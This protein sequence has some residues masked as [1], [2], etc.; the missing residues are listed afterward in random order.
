[1]H[2]IE[3][4][5]SHLAFALQAA[6]VG[7]WEW[8]LRSDSVTWSR[9]LRSICSEVADRFDGS[10][11]SAVALIQD[12]D[13]PRVVRAVRRAIERRAPFEVE[14]RHVLPDGGVQWV[15]SRGQ[16]MCDDA[17]EPARMLGIVMDITERKSA[18]LQLLRRD[19]VLEAV[20]FAA[21]Q[22]LRT[23]NWE[24]SAAEVLARLGRATDASRVYIIQM[25]AAPDGDALASMSFEWVAESIAPQ[26]D[27]PEMHGL[28]LV[29]AG[30]GRWIGLF[31]RGEVLEGNVAALPEGEQAMLRSQDIRSV[32]NVPVM[33]DG[34]WW[35]LL[36][37]DECVS[38]RDWS[39]AERELLQAAARTLGAAIERH[40]AEQELRGSQERF[41]QLV[42]NIHEVFWLSD[43]DKQRMLYVSPSYERIWGQRVDALYESAQAWLAAVH[44]D[45]RDWVRAAV[46]KQATGDYDIEYR[47][48]RPDGLVR[49][50]RDRAFPVT[51]ESGEVVRICG[52][53]EDVSRAKRAAKALRESEA[54]YRRLVTASPYGIYVLNQEGRFTE[55]NPAAEEIMG[56]AAAELLGLPFTELLS[57]DDLGDAL[58]VF[59]KLATG[60]SRQ[61]SF[62]VRIRRPDG[63]S[64]LLTAV[65]TAIVE[66]GAVTGLQ[67]IGR[68]ITE[69][70]ARDEQLRRAERLA[71]VGTMIGGVAHELNNPLAAIRGF[72]QLLMQD[73]RDGDDI[74]ALQTIDREAKRAAQIV[75]DLRLLAR[76]TQDTCERREAVDLN[77]IVQHVLKLRR[78][79]MET[80]NIELREDL[81]ADL[82]RVLGDRAQLEQVVLNLI[83]NAEQALQGHGGVRRIIIRTRASRGGVVLSVYDS[84]PGI[85][86]RHLDRIFDP[87]WTTKEPGEGTGL[88]LSLV[89]R[90]VSEHLGEIHVES[91]PGNGA[92]FMVR[93]PR[94]VGK[95][96]ARAVAHEPEVGASGSRRA[97]RVLVVDDEPPIRLLLRR[98]FSRRGD[99]VDE[100]S[101]GGEA[102]RRIDASAG[103]IPYDLIFSDLRMPG[104]DGQE[105]LQGL[106][107]RGEGWEK[108]LVIMT[109][110]AA[111]LDAERMLEEM[112]VPVMMKPFDLAE[113]PRLLDAVLGDEP[114]R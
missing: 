97:L 49:W 82:P 15:V 6:Q 45:D 39:A 112:G 64:R 76:A 59:Q 111:N 1:L 57:D 12:E 25:D 77:D 78:Y 35:G 20:R 42:D 66:D 80:R 23:G 43:R 63:E 31:S 100:A 109:G 73:E 103:G 69:E 27:S 90:I 8:D 44:P 95:P 105:L 2:A 52:I 29:G 84:G 79:G 21:E 104:L 83:V 19:A 3:N 86:P 51:D 37:F 34:V 46:S 96:E 93:L 67:G 9:G 88:G 81:M 13:R 74:D 60:T 108:R 68:D 102:L 41:L 56:R 110:D 14:Y 91:E 11:D 94:A 28:S 75:S 54:H 114:S 58:D 61:E 106:R 50:I 113:L 85:E 24:D 32:I 71:S 98:F 17:G 4:D 92:A 5:S 10:F 62:E 72:A 26:I 30:L 87:F 107:A 53:A 38:E 16:V 33:V 7:T 101:E 40:R 18:E 22:F 70:R 65:V 55:L 47:I 48:V 99:L 36:G 89:H